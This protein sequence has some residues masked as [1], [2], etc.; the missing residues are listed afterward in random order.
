[1]AQITG[2][3]TK[4]ELGRA[5]GMELKAIWAAMKRGGVPYPQIVDKIP[6]ADWE[7]IF[8][9]TRSAPTLDTDAA[10]AFLHGK[11]YRVTIEK[12]EEG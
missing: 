11:G 1:M 2:A 10:L 4:A 8:R 5:L 3:K 7:Y 6:P 9:G 12:R